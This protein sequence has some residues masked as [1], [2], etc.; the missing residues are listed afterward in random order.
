MTPSTLMPDTTEG[1]G[2]TEN[3]LKSILDAG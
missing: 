1:R 3:G 2:P